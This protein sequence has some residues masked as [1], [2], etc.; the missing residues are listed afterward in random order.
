MGNDKSSQIGV[1]LVTGLLAILGTV[2]GGVIKGYWDTSLAEKKFQTD[3]VMKSLESEEL[4]SRIVSLKFMIETNLIS[5]QTLR[6][7]LEEYLEK[8]PNVV[9]QF[10]AASAS[11]SSGIVVPSSE[12]TVKYTDY[13]VFV[14]DNSWNDDETQRIAASIIDTMLAGGRIGQVRLKKWSLYKEVPLTKLQGKVTIIVDK[15][16]GEAKEVPRLKQILESV[17]NIPDIQVVD[18]QGKKSAWLISIVICSAL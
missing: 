3:L 8:K 5:D 1:L 15:D 17:E 11:Y 10:K 7:G 14:C 18:N 12:E 16:H 13:D 9:P 2:A 6:T 4:E